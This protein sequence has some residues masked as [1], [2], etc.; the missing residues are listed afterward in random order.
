MKQLQ[1]SFILKS[2]CGEGYDDYLNLNSDHYCK[3]C[4]Q[5]AT[6]LIRNCDLMGNYP[7]N[8]F[9]SLSPANKRQEQTDFINKHCK[10]KCITE[11][12]Y[13][14]KQIIE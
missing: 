10:I 7:L 14:I 5:S 6:L 13:I 4:N 2:F 11:E 9:L 3:Y 1:H 8:Y 12:E